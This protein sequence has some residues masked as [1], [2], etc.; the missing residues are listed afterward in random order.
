VVFDGFI[1]G[2]ITDGR[3]CL[4]EFSNGLIVAGQQQ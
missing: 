1:I 4:G 2:E 3:T